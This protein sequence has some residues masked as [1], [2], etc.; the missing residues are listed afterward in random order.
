LDSGI[1]SL[2]STSLPSWVIIFASGS[3]SLVSY[4]A[5]NDGID[6]EPLRLGFKALYESGPNGTPDSLLLSGDGGAGLTDFRAGDLGSG[7]IA[8]GFTT[9]TVAVAIRLCRSSYVVA[10]GTNGFAAS[11]YD[12]GWGRLG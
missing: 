5:L 4:F 7:E 2:G 6:V 1:W 11:W 9:G 12:S 3:G 10:A 8:R